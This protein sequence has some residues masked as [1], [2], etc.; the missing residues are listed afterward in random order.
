MIEPGTYIFEEG[1]DK[2][3][4]I[5]WGITFITMNF[6]LREENDAEVFNIKSGSITVKENNGDYELTWNLEDENGVK[7]T[8]TYKGKLQ[9]EN[10]L[11]PV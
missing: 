7:I 2:L 3:F 5:G 10:N 4:S 11:I 9:N 8:G 6:A 1:E